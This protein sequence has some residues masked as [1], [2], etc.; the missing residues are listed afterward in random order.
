[1]KHIFSP[2]S[3][4]DLHSDAHQSQII[5]RGADED[6]TKIVGG[7]QSSPRVSALLSTWSSLV[8]FDNEYFSIFEH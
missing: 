6:H 8:S 4:T 5:G 3:S 2:I 7:I 1:M